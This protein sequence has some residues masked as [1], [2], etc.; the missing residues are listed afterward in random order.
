MNKN[1]IFKVK[2]ICLLYI[3]LVNLFPSKIYLHPLNYNL[4]K[5]IQLIIITFASFYDITLGV[6]LT[7]ILIMNIIIYE[8][9][10]VKEA[11]KMVITNEIKNNKKE[12][13]IE[14][15]LIKDIPSKN[16]K[17]VNDFDDKIQN[18]KLNNVDVSIN[19]IQKEQTIS[20]SDDENMYIN[21]IHKNID[22]ELVPDTTLMNDM[23]S[24]IYDTTNISKTVSPLKDLYETSGISAYEPNLY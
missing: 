10:T 21:N 5:F 3:V 18:D 12:Q 7:V 23:Q 14:K 15:T 1:L 24:N 17:I 4:S 22:K 9:K 8:T 2:I 6:L 16:K 11:K 13:K 19:K 20:I